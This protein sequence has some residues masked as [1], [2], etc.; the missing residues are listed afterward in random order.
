M[1]KHFAASFSVFFL[2]SCSTISADKQI[3]TSSIVRD[4][5]L[6]TYRPITPHLNLS[7]DDES[8]SGEVYHP[9]YTGE[10]TINSL[11]NN[12]KGSWPSL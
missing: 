6:D 12:R 5:S 10:A 11:Q 2:I 3:R 8:L 4:L 9:V 7:K 1:F